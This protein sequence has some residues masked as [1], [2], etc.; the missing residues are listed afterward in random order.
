VAD[1]YEDLNSDFL[2]A[3]SGQGNTV[4]SQA[5]KAGTKVDQGSTIRIFLSN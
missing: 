1:I 3:K 5:P 4:I 2:L